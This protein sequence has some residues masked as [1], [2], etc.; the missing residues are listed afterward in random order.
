MNALAGSA[1]P[2]PSLLAHYTPPPGVYDETVNAAGEVRE[3]WRAFIQGLDELGPADLQRRWELAQRQ[4]TRDG[5]TFNPY[6]QDVGSSRPWV[7]DAMPLLLREQEWSE[8]EAGLAQRARLFDLILRDLFGPQQ[9]LQDQLLPPEALFAHPAYYPSYHGLHMGDHGFLQLYAADIA[10]S[11]DGQWWVVSDRSR[12]PFGLGYV[13]EN[14]IVTSRMLPTQFRQCKVERLASFFIT[15]KESLRQQAPRFKDNPRVAIWTSGPSSRAYFEDAYLARYLGYQLVEGGDLAVRENRVM[16]KTLGG[17]LPV[18]V[19]FRRLNDDDCDPVELD[20]NSVNGVAGLLEVVRGGNVSLANPLGSR[21]V[22]SPLFMSFLPSICRHL[23][24]EELRMPSVATW[25]CGDKQGLSYVLEHLDELMIRKA[26]RMMD[27]VPLRPS[28][29]T[30]ADR[31]LLVEALKARPQDY[32]GQQTITRSTTPVWSQ[33]AA[34]P[35]SLALRSFLVRKDDDFLALPGGLARVASDPLILEQTMTTGERSQDVWIL[36]D[37]AIEEVTLLTPPGQTIALRRSGAELPSRVADHLFWLGR[38]VERSEGSARLLRTIFNSVTGER[39]YGPELNLLL[40]ALADQ[41]QIDS[42]F[43]DPSGTG[44]VPN[45]EVMLPQAI[46]D[47][48]RPKSLRFSI[49]QCVRL[50][51]IVRDRVAID[52]WRII[53]RLDEASR[54]P[55]VDVQEVIELLDRVILDLAAFSGLA[56]ESMTRTQGW[57]FLD[58]G[59]RVERAWQTSMLLRSTLTHIAEDEVAVLESVMQTADSIMTYRSRYLATVQPAAVLDLLITDETNPRSIGSQLAAIAAHV[60]ELPRDGQQAVRS[61]E[62]R[63]ALSLLN[64]VRLAEVHEL[65]LATQYGQREALDRL[66]KRLCDQLPKLSDAMSSRFLIHAGL[67]RHFGI[68]ADPDS[69]LPTGLPQL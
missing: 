5:F 54:R 41:G 24:G 23:L 12:A 30:Q 56:S 51:S 57:R 65:A 37:E 62:Q 15:L 17:L 43:G 60:D 18:E 59:R 45:V 7:L 53:H 4:V 31:Q 63:L 16:L 34:V 66:L 25:W 50:V 33:Q 29:M 64:A 20:G 58:L 52:A 19:I 14:R 49:M 3:P 69:G 61:P 42:D 13:L 55:L 10:R 2:V 11:P 35:W 27:D 1:S 48:Q 8:I 67:P 36:S 38:N 47:T 6:E 44:T 9:L 26:F 28:L 39:E 68:S 22:E 32:V 46:F 40:Q 21:L